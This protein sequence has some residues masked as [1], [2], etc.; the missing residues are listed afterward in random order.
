M[1]TG[2]LRTIV[3]VVLSLLAL[4]PPDDALATDDQGAQ[5]RPR[6]ALLQVNYPQLVSVSAGYWALL[7][8]GGQR[9]IGGVGDLEVGLSGP[10]AKLGIGTTTPNHVHYEGIWSL[11]VQAVVHRTWPWWTPSLATSTTFAGGEIFA[12]AFVIRCSAGAL[13][14]IGGEGSVVFTGGCGLATP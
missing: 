3:L 6:F 9:R 5:L 12:A 14:S 13:R 4:F 8:G 10:V 2:K 11:G 7:D 1:K